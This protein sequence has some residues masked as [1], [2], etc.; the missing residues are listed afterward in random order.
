MADVKSLLAEANAAV[1]KIGVNEA[2]RLVEE[3]GALLVDVRDGPELVSAGKLTGAVHV[4]RGMIEFHADPSTPYHN[5][6]FR[7][8]R[9]I[10]L[11]CA[12]GGRSALAA[13]SL[14]DLGYQRTYNLG[15][16]KDAAD[17]GFET[18]SA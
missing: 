9:P 14:Q 18:E 4:S 1:P 3:E 6:E 10:I 16:F 5:A 17:G 11:Y 7:T 2:Q 13:K 12:S 8:D 15:G